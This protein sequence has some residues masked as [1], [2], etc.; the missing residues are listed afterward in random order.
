MDIR[1]YFQR[2]IKRLF[3]YLLR[4]DYYLPIPQEEDYIFIKESKLVGI[5]M[6]ETV[7]LDLLENTINPYKGEF[8]EFPL[9]KTQDPKQFYVINGSFMSIDSNV[10]YA[11]IRHYQPGRIVEVGSGN[12]TLLAAAAIGKNKNEN[13]KKT[14]NMVC[15]DPYPSEKVKGKTRN[16]GLDKL[17]IKKVQE[18]GLDFFKSLKKGDI[19]FID[20]THTLRPGGDVW[21][22]YC[23]VLPR[24][25]PGVL[26]HVHDIELPKSYPE[27]YFDHGWYW[28]EQYLLQAFLAFNSRFEVI[29][30]GSYMMAKYP[31]RMYKT[32]YPE[33][34][35]ERQK[36]PFAWPSSF[37]MRVKK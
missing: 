2:G 28:T 12:S 37:W 20:S 6:G 8:N 31:K 22:L 17:I 13:S 10:Y 14:T 9:Y 18:V 33:Y 32:F 1:Q 5:D 4:K 16:L 15:I 3:L 23:E 26:I 11:F 35:L 30:P 24:L 21:W 7:A 25:A 27:V 29:W 19:L 34:E 36:Y